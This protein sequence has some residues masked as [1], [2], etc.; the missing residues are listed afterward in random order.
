MSQN[1]VHGLGFLWGTLRSSLLAALAAA[2][3]LASA[4]PSQAST[5]T[6]RAYDSDGRLLS[7]RELVER[8]SPRSSKGRGTARSSALFVTDLDGNPVEGRPWWAETST[9]AVLSWKNATRIKLSLPWPVAEEGFSTVFLDK[10][11]AGYSD[12]DVVDLDAEILA[13]MNRLF[14]ESLKDRTASWDP[15][16]R[17]S[18]KALKRHRN[19]AEMI[20]RAR[21]APAE[22]RRARHGRALTQLSR[23]WSQ[24]LA[25]HGTQLARHARTGPSLRWGLTLDETLHNRLGEHDRIFRQLGRSGATWVRLVFRLNPNDFEFADARSFSDYDRIVAELQSRRIHVMASVLDGALWPKAMPAEALPARTKNLVRH[26]KD[27][28]RSWE[29]ASEPNGT[30]LGGWRNPL[31]NETVI[32]AITSAAAA[33]KRQDSSLETV[34]TLYWWEGTA[35]DDTHATFPWLKRTIPQ[36]VFSQIDLVA[37]S[38]YPDEN[39]M[40]MAFD[41]VFRRLAQY[42]PEK[43][44]MLGGFGYVEGGDLTGYWW[45]DPDD[46]EGARADLVALYTPAACAIPRSAGGGFWWF[47][48]SQMFHPP[49]AGETLYRTYQRTL[50]DLGR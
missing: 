37:L 36:G 11:G 16:Y 38:I 27:R 48:L 33:V 45:L 30:W 46:V 20:E 10:E 6:L 31:P 28:I 41:P 1:V 2:A 19:L 23:A 7:Q 40:G 26:Y 12:G 14:L 42:F 18:R 43:R 24:M 32:R 3:A 44:L 34:A 9:A 39:P 15:P 21:G 25:E 22:E 4:A 5:L 29:V 47:T 49:R 17:P 50:W 35:G 8:I 13:T